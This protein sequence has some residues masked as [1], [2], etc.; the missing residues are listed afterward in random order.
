MCKKSK[1]KA[2]KLSCAKKINVKFLHYNAVL[3][4]NSNLTNSENDAEFFDAISDISGKEKNVDVNIINYV[5]N[6]KH[7]IIRELKNL[8]LLLN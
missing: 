3:C 7:T 8:L 4:Y 5:I 6:Q 2:V 1:V